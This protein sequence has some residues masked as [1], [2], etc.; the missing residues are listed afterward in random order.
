MNQDTPTSW[1]KEFSDFWWN[2]PAAPTKSQEYEAVKAFIS[3]LL[4][5]TK[6]ADANSSPKWWEKE[7][8]NFVEAHHTTTQVEPR[9]LK[10]VDVKAFISYI[11]ERDTLK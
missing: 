11:L 7:F 1:E 2:Q 6:E 9:L 8:S 3:S 4:F 5:N 10:D